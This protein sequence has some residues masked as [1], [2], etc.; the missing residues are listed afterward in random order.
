MAAGDSDL[1]FRS[2]SFEIGQGLSSAFVAASEP[3]VAAVGGW[4]ASSGELELME[5]CS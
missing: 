4:Q 3:A 2:K 5:A 1:A